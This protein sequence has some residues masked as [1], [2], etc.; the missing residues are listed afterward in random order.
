MEFKLAQLD[1]KNILKDSISGIYYTRRDW[2]KLMVSDESVMNDWADWRIVSRTYARYRVIT[3]EGYI[4]RM[5]DVPEETAV[6]YLESLFSLTEGWNSGER[7][8]YIMDTYDNEWTIK[9]KVKEPFYCDYA[10]TS[11]PEAAWKWRVVLEST[12]DPIYKS[13]QEVIESGLEWQYGWMEL[14]CELW[15]EL[16]DY[17]NIIECQT[18]G[19]LPTPAKFV[20]TATANI[21][22]P[23][24]IRN[25][26]A[27]NEFVLNIDA[28]VWDIIVIDSNTYTVTKNWVN[29]IANRVEWSVFPFISGTT[30]FTIFDVDW[31]LYEKDLTIDIYFR[32]N[33]L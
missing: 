28:V 19:N 24:T 4:D 14:E 26:T 32:D 6:S 29:T 5:W 21:N 30:L 8:L 11:F 9:V 22:K 12:S 10:D 20:I 25:L 3:L 18:L 17:Y 13:Y 31:D 16:D 2:K 27:W 1:W 15:S 23:L 33:L 7:E